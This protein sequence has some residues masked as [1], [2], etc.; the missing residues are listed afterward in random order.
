MDT[1]GT[2]D[3]SLDAIPDHDLFTTDDE[4]FID[5][6]SPDDEDFNNSGHGSDASPSTP[7]PGDDMS[8][9]EDTDWEDDDEENEEDEELREINQD[10]AN[11][12]LQSHLLLE[13]PKSP[14]AGYSEPSSAQ[15]PATHEQLLN[16]QPGTRALRQDEEHRIDS[17]VTA[18]SESFKQNQSRVRHRKLYSDL[19]I[20]ADK[21]RSHKRAKKHSASEKRA[22]KWLAKATDN[23][24]SKVAESK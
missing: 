22:G 17:A 7:N 24:L 13:Q 20:T 2:A 16:D 15:P 14:E 19:K 5:A 6:E 1:T 12:D 18:L 8:D 21:I 23:L 3:L 4:S 9:N 10:T 11:E